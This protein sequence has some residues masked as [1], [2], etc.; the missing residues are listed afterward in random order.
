[1]SLRMGVII[2]VG[3]SMLILTLAPSTIPTIE[4]T[5]CEPATTSEVA[6]GWKMAVVILFAAAFIMLFC[7]ILLLYR[8]M[9]GVEL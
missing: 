8:S 4:K 9:C 5:T 1:M 3:A 2:A 7:L 6:P